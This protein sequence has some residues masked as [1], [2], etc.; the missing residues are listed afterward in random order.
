MVVGEFCVCVC[1][2]SGLV[3]AGLACWS[4]GLKC[5]REWSFSG[6]CVCILVLL[7][8]GWWSFGGR[9]WQNCVLET[10]GV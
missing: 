10:F 4:G 9:G 3:V 5:M 8:V 7:F 6:Q 2:P 1:G